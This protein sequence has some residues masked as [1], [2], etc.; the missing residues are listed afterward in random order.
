MKRSIIGWVVFLF[1]V[2]IL[3][4]SLPS[5]PGTFYFFKGKVA[6]L[7]R[8]PKAAAEAFQQAV[9]SDPQFV[10]GYVELGSC[11]LAL[12][13][14]LEAEQALKKA[15]SLSNDA[16]AA[17]GLGLVYYSTTRYDEAEKVFKQA[18]QFDP[19]DDCAY[20]GIGKLYYDQDRYQETIEAFSKAIK[21]NPKATSYHYLGNTYNALRRFDDALDAY[22]RLLK[23]NPRYSA[24][25]ADLGMSYYWLK[26]Y[27]EA[28]RAFQHAAE[29]SED[30][31]RAYFGMGL[32]QLALGQ[33]QK[34][35]DQYRLLQSLEPQWAA[36]LLDEINKGEPKLPQSKP[37]KPLS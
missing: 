27:E 26:R 1:L 2:G 6:Q 16:C 31:P 34:A 29:F 28:G 37:D 7:S 5:A 35:M 32:V 18:I 15:L 33:R 11:Y 10:R 20:E 13:Q 21:L 14:P 23:L 9:D 19:N 25:Y 24:V 36:L 12:K 22:Q 3:I 30:D 17:C 8:D 4:H